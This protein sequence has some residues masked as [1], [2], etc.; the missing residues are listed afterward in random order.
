MRIGDAHGAELVDG[1]AASAFS[2]AF[3][4][5]LA[6]G[7]RLHNEMEAGRQERQGSSVSDFH[8]FFFSCVCA[9]TKGRA[10]PVEKASGKAKSVSSKQQST[11]STK[12]HP[13]VP[14]KCLRVRSV[15]SRSCL[16]P[17]LHPISPH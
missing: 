14:A 7:S 6:G 5:F 1:G 11:S 3:P 12:Q 10:L 15:V 13:A 2:L 17:A 9:E 16:A 8:F 4:L